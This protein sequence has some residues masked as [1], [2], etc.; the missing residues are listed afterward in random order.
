MRVANDI[1]RKLTCLS[2]GIGC[3]RGVFVECLDKPAIGIEPWRDDTARSGVTLVELVMSMAVMSMMMV[4]L[5]GLSMTV[6]EGAEFNRGYGEIT[7]HARIVSSHITHTINRAAATEDTPGVVVLDEVVGGW[8]FPDTLVVWSPESGEPVDPAKGPL[9]SELVVFTPNPSAPNELWE[10]TDRGNSALATSLIDYANWTQFG[11]LTGW[12]N[13]VAA[14]VASN[15]SS[16]VVLTDRL[17]IASTSTSDLT[18]TSLWRG[19]IRF[20]SDIRPSRNQW[21]SYKATPSTW[22]NLAWAQG[23]HGSQ[24]GLRQ[25]TVRFEFHLQPEASTVAGDSE[26]MPPLPFFGSAALRYEMHR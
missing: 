7:Q 18:N 1:F 8:R 2:R 11:T 20:E 26:V 15:D 5:A 6:Q 17:R 12:Q 24:T 3:D 4:G 21:W 16:K 9:V 22:N 10:L 25:T 19:C 23:I 13:C 14:M